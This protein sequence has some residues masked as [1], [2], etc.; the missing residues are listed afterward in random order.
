MIGHSFNVGGSS[1]VASAYVNENFKGGVRAGVR[2][3]AEGTYDEVSLFFALVRGV[4]PAVRQ[5]AAHF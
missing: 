1:R 3:D 5:F 2:G 4:H